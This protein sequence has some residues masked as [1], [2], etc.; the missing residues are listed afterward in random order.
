MKEMPRIMSAMVARRPIL[1]VLFGQNKSPN[2]WF[3]L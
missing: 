3:A 2:A 1:A